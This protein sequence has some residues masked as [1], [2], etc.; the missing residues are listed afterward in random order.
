MKNLTPI[1][2]ILFFVN[3]CHTA[4]AG[5]PLVVKGGMAVSYGTRAYTYRYDKGTL[6]MF[7]NSEAVALIEELYKDW[8]AVKTTEIKFQ[9][10]NPG[11][12]DFDINSSNFDSILN[13]QDLLGYTPVIFDN[14]GSLLNAFLGSGAGN[15]VLGLSGPITVSSGPLVNQIAESQAIF[16]GRFANGINTPSD[17]ETTSDSFK[18]TVIHETG[19]GLGLDHAQIN[20][21]AIKPGASQELQDTV[22]LMFPV[23][24]N[25]LFLIRRDDASAISFLYPNQSQLSGFGKIEGKL[26]RQDGK[27]P[28]IGGN[29]IA[30]NINDPKLEAISCV[31]D[32]LSD[33]SGLF[34]LFAVPP[35]SYKIE[36]EPIDLSFTG[37]SG[38]G[39]FTASKSDKSFQNPV[40]KGFYAGPNK[41]ITTDENQALIV[42]VQTGQTINN[43]NI[44]AST[45]ASSSSSTS[46]SSGGGPT[47]ISE[48]EPNDSISKAQSIT[49]PTTITGNASSTDSGEIELSSDTEGKVIISDLFKFNVSAP[50]NITAL[51]TITSELQSN[52]LD[53]VL[54]TG[55]ASN[56]VD[57]SSQTGNVDELISTSIQPG[58]YLLGVGAFTGT[59]PY[60]LEVTLTSNSSGPALLSLSG[61]EAIIL[62]PVGANKAVLTAKGTN[63]TTKS[64]CQVFTTSENSTVAKIKPSIFSLSPAMTTKNLRFSIPKIAALSAIANNQKDTITVNITCDNGALDDLDIL[65][66]PNAED[67]ITRKA[68]W[69][70]LRNQNYKE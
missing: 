37:G 55:D 63:F 61:P 53:L 47:N 31:S 28:V 60:K 10:D 15:S 13:S 66:T 70:I 3:T 39:P 17:P 33:G 62:K 34:T 9:Q 42:T 29:V 2:I 16:N 22:P 1:L 49:P 19:H 59:A 36:I 41:S 26:F 67:V 20:V 68:N 25:D 54:F 11:F 5:G 38:V 69:Q 6:G 50:S 30:R 40:P 18:G 58:S 52:D 32:Y 7:S 35:G 27:T 21:E 56:I 14:D 43:I 51:L 4:F 45:T 65:V 23:A 64:K 24:V 12:L 57:T 8:Q 48:V 44:I 46:S